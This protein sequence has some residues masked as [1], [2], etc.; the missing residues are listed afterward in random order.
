MANFDIFRINGIDNT[1][2]SVTDTTLAVPDYP[3]DSKAVGDAL[4]QINSDIDDLR[5]EA[6]IEK[7]GIKYRID[8]DDEGNVIAVPEEEQNREIVKDGLIA[9]FKVVD[10]VV[11]DL[12]SGT[13][14]PDVTVYHSENAMD[15]S[16]Y[17]SKF[18][19]VPSTRIATIEVVAPRLYTG[20]DGG[21]GARYFRFYFPDR[22]AE[23]QFG[24][25]CNGTNALNVTGLIKA[26]TIYTIGPD[27]AGI[28]A[29]SSDTSGTPYQYCFC[30]SHQSERLMYY[31]NWNQ[32]PA[33]S[34]KCTLA[35][36]IDSTETVDASKN[37]AM[38]INGLLM[39]NYKESNMFPN[40]PFSITMRGNNA[41]GRLKE[42]RVYNRIL[43]ED[44]IINNSI[45]DGTCYKTCSS[46]IIKRSDGY[47]NFGSNYAAAAVDGISPNRAIDSEISIG[48]H[49]DEYG[50]S[51][52]IS[53]FTPYTEPARTDGG[54]FEG[55][56]FINKPTTLYTFRKY[57]VVAYPYP[58]TG[59]FIGNGAE[60]S[61]HI[62]YSSSD[63]SI[64]ACVDGVLIPK[65]E[66][67]V[68]ITARLAGTQLTDSFTATVEVY[69][70]SVSEDDTL[71]VP[72]NYTYGVHA[73]TSK[74]PKS[75]ARAMFHAIKQAGEEG[76]KKIVFP[77]MDYMIYPVI[78]E[79]STNVQGGPWCCLVPSNLVIDFNDSN[80]YIPENPVC[81]SV[82]YHLF[83]FNYGCE[84][85][86]IENATFYGEL[87][88]NKDGHAQSEYHAGCTII[89]Y[90]NAYMCG[91]KNLHFIDVV[92]F[93][94]HFSQIQQYDYYG[95]I[96]DANW[97]AGSGLANR[98]RILKEE[99]ELG[100]YDENGNPITDTNHIRTV[101]KMSIGYE[102]EDL[103]T[104]LFG[105]MGTTY[106]VVS[107]RWLKVWWYDKNNNLL[108]PGGTLYFQYSEYHLPEG[109]VSFKLS[110]YQSTL[111]DRNRGEDNCVLRIYP[112]KCARHC[113]CLNFVSD[114]PNGWGLTNTGGQ[115]LYVGNAS[116]GRARRWSYYSIDH[117]NE[118]QTTQSC[119]Y[120]NIIGVGINLYGGFGHAILSSAMMDGNYAVNI[121]SDNES[122]RVMNC[123]IR[124]LR[125]SAKTDC[126]YRGIKY[127]KVTPTTPQGSYIETDMEVISNFNAI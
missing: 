110:A 61:F 56:G 124:H 51:Y 117:E 54:T 43:S 126:V 50:N 111:P 37:K 40:E 31:D 10:G 86:S 55:I 46:L 79:E 106:Y 66:G 47:A 48:S 19:L 29:F 91:T 28:Q 14:Y 59:S 123:T 76:Y 53:N 105:F 82:G 99:F 49:T 118:Y 81:F 120:D 36:M 100:D 104:F 107:S 21:T 45:V 71:Y 67:T 93:G 65:A 13:T 4:A 62:M 39:P 78:D 26:H 25:V 35:T 122:C 2:K 109:A 58:F 103:E 9:H 74:S 119:V 6:T 112:M 30:D 27:F 83:M 18:E 87:Y 24:P 44:E 15:G 41:E 12:V 22:N 17:K 96:R 102:P 84:Y 125:T 64:C 20:E 34:E 68:T 98:G 88:F 95:G 69:D 90:F 77:K 127:L 72:K 5:S 16:F 8:I 89:H 97:T 113:Y 94:Y 121:L 42:V 80:I 92:G 108:N 101:T 3:A 63:E 32:Y 115:Q 7:D 57:S 33:N 70:N 23:A 116:I 73:L 60:G 85:S 52:S 38:A 11:T 114:R 75:C 1:L